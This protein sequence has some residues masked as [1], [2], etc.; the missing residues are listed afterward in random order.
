MSKTFKAILLS[1]LV[2][3]GAGQIYLKKYPRGIALIVIATISV[4]ALVT[5]ILREA[6]TILEQIQAEGGVVGV[7]R[8]MELTAQA[9]A[10]GDG[11]LKSIAVAVL[12]VCWLFGVIDCY[13]QGKQQS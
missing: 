8:I 10:A 12:I 11:S 2:F 1:G 5:V 3:P 7:D 13:L 9:E 4:A 6:Q